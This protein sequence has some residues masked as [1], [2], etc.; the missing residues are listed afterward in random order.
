[1]IIDGTNG[2][3]FNNATTQASAGCVL[4]VVQATTTTQVSNSTT[5]FVDTNLTATITPK[6]T[7]SKV[8]VIVNQSIW[9]QTTNVS[10][11]VDLKLI[12]NSTDLGRFAYAILFTNSALEV[13]GSVSVSY[14]DSPAST[15]AV[16]YKTQLANQV[17][18][19]SVKCQPDSI[20]PSYITLMEIAG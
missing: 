2:L 8:L 5:T 20:A 14:L 9:K 7:T 17:N 10:N 13:Y 16:T 15:S 6:F 3:T 1:M 19:A 4:Q 12:R 11:G 18:T